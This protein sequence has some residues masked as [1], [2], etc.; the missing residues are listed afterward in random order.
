MEKGEKEPNHLE[1][2]WNFTMEIQPQ[3]NLAFGVNFILNFFIRL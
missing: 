2:S 3:H 1:L